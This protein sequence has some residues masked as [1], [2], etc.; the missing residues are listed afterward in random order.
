MVK[1]DQAA[2]ETGWTDLESKKGCEGRGRFVELTPQLKKIAEEEFDTGLG[3]TI[4]TACNPAESTIT[5][6][7]CP[8][9]G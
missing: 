9:V 3:I 8:I 4:N 2:G 1:R 6:D 7:S 5:L